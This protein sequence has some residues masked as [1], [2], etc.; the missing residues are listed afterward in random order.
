MQ[1]IDNDRKVRKVIR[2]LPKAWEVKATT[3][4]ELND[5]EEMDF[6]DFIENLKIHEMK[7]KVCEGRKPTKKSS[8]TFKA[9]PSIVEDEKSTDEG[10]EDFAMLIRKMGKMFYK[11]ERQSNFQKKKTS[12]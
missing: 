9:T 5:R 11:K 6:S 7:M 4:K 2:A 12:R 3:H 1:S 8:I 10:E